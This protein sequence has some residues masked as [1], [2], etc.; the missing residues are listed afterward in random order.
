M[1]DKLAR[2]MAG[3]RTVDVWPP[4]FPPRHARGCADT[5]GGQGRL[6]G[7][8][9][10]GRRLGARARVASRLMSTPA[11]LGDVAG[12]LL[13]GEPARARRMAI[14]ILQETDIRT[15]KI[16]SRKYR[17]VWLANPKVASRS[18]VAALLGAD[19]E[20][21][22]VYENTIFEIYARYPETKDY[23]SFAFVRHPFDRAASYHAQLHRSREGYEGNVLSKVERAIRNKFVRFYGLAEARDFDDYCE[24]L[25][26]PYG[27]DAFANRH[28]LSQY[29]VIRAGRD[30]LPDF[31]GRLENLRADLDRVA[32]DVG[33]PTPA[34]PMLNTMGGWQA[35][36]E[37]LRAVRS[38]TSVQLTERNKALLRKRYAED[39][40]LGG[41]SP[42]GQENQGLQ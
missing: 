21:E 39:F 13:H 23:Y 24:W 10:L 3:E 31:I 29:L 7:L 9:K 4:R 8:R 42:R 37:A 40:R 1:N 12:A 16:I 26:T 19:P 38:R 11:V 35:T 22:I 32:A 20:A 14:T 25:D 28:F 18:I 41:Y 36:P 27:S 34:L 30:R 17:F 5:P 33:M 6:E 15:E 2:F